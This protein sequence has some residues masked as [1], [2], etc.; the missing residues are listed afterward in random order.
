MILVDYLILAIYNLRYIIVKANLSE[1]F[2]E[3]YYC[4]FRSVPLHTV[5]W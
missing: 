5:A 2:D 4:I 1:N 3:L